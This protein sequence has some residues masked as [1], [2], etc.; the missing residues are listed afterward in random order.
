MSIFYDDVDSQ[1]YVKYIYIRLHDALD[2]DDLAREI[3]RLYDDMAH[4]FYE[5]TGEKI[6]DALGWNKAPPT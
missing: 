2:S 6:G 5:D 1:V 3:S 4:T